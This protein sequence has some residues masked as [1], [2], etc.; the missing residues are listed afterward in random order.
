MDFLTLDWNELHKKTFELSQKLKGQKIDLIVAIA[1]GGLAISHILSDFLNTSVT[2]FTISSYSNLKQTN[3]LN[4]THKI[5]ADPKNKKILLVDDVS[6]S[7][8]T[9]MKGIEYLRG[10][11]TEEILTASIFIKPE[12]KYKPDFYIGETNSWIVFPYEMRETIE[13]LYNKFKQDGL[14]DRAIRE[15]LKDMRLEEFF[16]DN[17]L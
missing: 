4:I 3:Q 7:G 9:F 1:R 11:G 12:T 17:Y 6:D 2:S 5:G 8:K 13:A 10:L 16:I 14:T 15:K